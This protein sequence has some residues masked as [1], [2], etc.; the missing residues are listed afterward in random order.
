MSHQVR[1]EEVDLLM[2]S[3]ISDAYL[4]HP[5]DDGA[6][7]GVLFIMDAIGLRPRIADMVSR[8]ASWGYAVLAPNTF[9]RAGRQPLV[10]P[11]LLTVE[12]QAERMARF[13][14]LI[15]SL[16]PGLWA[17]D[18]PAYLDHLTALAVVAHDVPTRVVG[19]CM[20]GRL[21]LTLAAQR[22]E[23]VGVVAGFHPGGLVTDTPDS[24]HTLLDRVRARVY[25]GYADN[26][27]SMP[28]AAQETLAAAARTAG[29]NLTGELYADAAH[30]F[31]MADV[32]AYNADAE[33]R[34]WRELERVFTEG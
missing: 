16:T 11:E 34:H 9:Y 24:P 21:A 29:C 10:A 6:W 17:A 14:E 32:P 30:G 20:G 8:I 7:P 19:Y 26:D 5:A 4:A 28:A 27:G 18:G 22:P 13:G 2:P 33:A 23:Q 12:R 3:G 31:T 25:F 15:P 1:V